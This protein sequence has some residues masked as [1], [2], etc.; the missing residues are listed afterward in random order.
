MR[1]SIITCLLVAAL[2]PALVHAEPRVRVTTNMGEFVIELDPERAPITVENFLRYV[3]EGFYSGT[4]F[5]RV[6]AGFVVQG[7]GHSATDYSL[8]PT[9]EPI[10]NESGNGL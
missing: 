3:R 5:H 4:L 10:A 1:R 9:H 6:V 2:L 7:G 8:K